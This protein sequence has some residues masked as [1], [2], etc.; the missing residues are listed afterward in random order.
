MYC[1]KCGKQNIETNRFCRYCGFN[2]NSDH[3]VKKYKPTGKG[4]NNIVIGPV[5]CSCD[6]VDYFW[7]IS[8]KR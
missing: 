5:I 7:H 6:F 3:V 8:Y 1:P 4:R 2:L